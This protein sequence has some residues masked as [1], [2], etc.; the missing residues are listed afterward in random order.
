MASQA[1]VK[2]KKWSKIC[3]LTPELL[4]IF[5]N[6]KKENVR[7]SLIG[8]LFL[9]IFRKY[10]ILNDTELNLRQLAF[11]TTYIYTHISVWK[12]FETIT[13]LRCTYMLVWPNL[14]PSPHTLA[15]CLCVCTSLPLWRSTAVKVRH[16]TNCV[17]V[18]I[19]SELISLSFTSRLLR[20]FFYQLSVAHE[21][22]ICLSCM[23]KTILLLF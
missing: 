13:L 21:H 3:R 7:T 20:S 11:G 1:T 6:Y 10:N 19:Q 8:S 15:I 5:R 17:H 2:S 18:P 9:V 23:S 16:L 22:F 12:F 4:T 14:Y